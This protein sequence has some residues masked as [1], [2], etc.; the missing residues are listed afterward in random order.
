MNSTGVSRIDTP[1]TK[2]T[3]FTPSDSNTESFPTE[4]GQTSPSCIDTFNR[5]VEDLVAELKGTFPELEDIIEE[6]YS[7]VSPTDASLLEWFE[8]N[9]KEHHAALTA[10]D[11]SVFKTNT[12]LFLLPDIN[13]SQLWKCKLTKSNKNAIWKYLH[14]LMLLVSHHNMQGVTQSVLGATADASADSSSAQPAL[15][16]MQSTFEHWNKM[17]D[18]KQLSPQE[19]QSMKEQSEKIMKLMETLHNSNKEVDEEE[20][21]ENSTTT[22]ESRS[23]GK[24]PTMEDLKNDPF[25]KQL[26]SSK[27]AQFAKELTD[28]L[29]LKDMGLADDTKAQSFQDV[30]GMMGKDPQKMFGLV[31]TVGDKIQKKMQS[32][33]IQQSELLSE[34]QNLMQSMQT[35]DTFKQ[36]FKGRK[37]GRR[38]KGGDGGGFDPH[39]LFK[40]MT[41]HIDPA[42]MQQAMSMMGN[43]QGMPGMPGMQEMQQMVGGAGGGAT[44]ARLQ[45]K[46]AQRGDTPTYGGTERAV[47]VTNANNQPKLVDVSAPE[48]KKK[49]KKKVRQGEKCLP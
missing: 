40:E 28:E 20:D 8:A 11:E 9:A 7:S 31:K 27:I 12:S 43:M 10:K 44:R 5:T 4:I 24:G 36:M 21:E 49:R 46:L 23:G 48:K 13:F 25:V 29:D 15:Q 3:S 14:V 39:M 2:D 1:Y 26:E 37:K 41:K 33:D 38:G 22:N 35:S 18:D 30:F 42:M 16:N 45:Q 17:L 47:S 19:L 34:A 32:G 6:R